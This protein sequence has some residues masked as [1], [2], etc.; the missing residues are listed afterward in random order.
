MKYFLCI[1]ILQCSLFISFHSHAEQADKSEVKDKK[2]TELTAIVSDSELAF[3]YTR[4]PHPSVSIASHRINKKVTKGGY[5]VYEH[6]GKPTASAKQ[7]DVWLFKKGDAINT[8]IFARKSTRHENGFDIYNFKNNKLLYSIQSFEFDP[9]YEQANITVEKYPVDTEGNRTFFGNISSTGEFDGYVCDKTNV[10][11]FYQCYEIAG[12]HFDNLPEQAPYY[13]H[14]AK[15]KYTLRKGYHFRFVNEAG[16]RELYT[17]VQ[18]SRRAKAIQTYNGENLY[19]LYHRRIGTFKEELFYYL[20]PTGDPVYPY[21]RLK[22]KGRDNNEYVYLYSKD[23]I[24]SANLSTW[25]GVAAADEIT[26]SKDGNIYYMNNDELFSGFANALKLTKHEYRDLE[27]KQLAKMAEE[28][29]SRRN[30]ERRKKTSADYLRENAARAAEAYGKYA[31]EKARQEL[32]DIPETSDLMQ[33]LYDHA[34]QYYGTLFV[35]N[36]TTSTCGYSVFTN[37]GQF[38]S[39]TVGPN[40]TVNVALDAARAAKATIKSACP[41]QHWTK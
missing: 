1:L 9:P 21:F 13:A 34:A 23:I 12:R 19:G 30:L 14:R 17:Y 35:R 25:I 22:P 28:A 11:T 5:D 39:G 3:P 24:D 4:I 16:T 10:D 8:E 33:A 36:P 41:L 37:D 15:I 20:L 2:K 7:P 6:F 27:E 38:E 31:K 40:Q 32:Y 29:R 18:N 26:A